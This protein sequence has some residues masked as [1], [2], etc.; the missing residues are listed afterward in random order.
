MKKSFKTNMRHEL[1]IDN[2]YQIIKLLNGKITVE[3]IIYKK[4][5]K[6]K[7]TDKTAIITGHY[8]EDVISF[9]NQCWNID[10]AITR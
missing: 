6:I 8:E 4:G 5:M 2:P 7:K 9:I 1:L 3:K 10:Y